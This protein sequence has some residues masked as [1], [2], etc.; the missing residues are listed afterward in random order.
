MRETRNM[1]EDEKTL[2]PLDGFKG[3]I[4]TLPHCK[5]L[6]IRF[7]KVSRGSCEAYIEYGDHLAGDPESGIIHGGVITTLM[8]TLGGGC[9]FSLV[10]Q[11]QSAATLDLRIDYLKPAITK[12]RINGFAE[13]Y[14]LTQNIAFVRGYAFNRD[15][16]RPIAHCAATFVI[17]SVGFSPSVPK[18]STG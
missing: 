16:E 18:E 8:D 2:Y 3:V 11:G 6:G 17:G 5:L 14:K 4:E 10:Q 15:R 7:S 13:C 1:P 12:E 9:V